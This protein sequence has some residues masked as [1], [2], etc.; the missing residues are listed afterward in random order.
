M[1]IATD[2]LDQMPAKVEAV[3][4]QH[5]AQADHREIKVA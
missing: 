1:T 5:N 3:I 2:V 4:R